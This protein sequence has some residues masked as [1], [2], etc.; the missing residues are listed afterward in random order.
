MTDPSQT[1]LKQTVVRYKDGQRSH[2]QDAVLIEEPLEIRLDCNPIAITMRTPGHDTA[3]ALGFLLSE[4][5]IDGLNDVARVVETSED[6]STLINVFPTDARLSEIASRAIRRGTI[7]S[8]SCGVCGRQQ[9]DDLLARCPPIECELRIE[10]DRVAAAIQSLDSAQTLFTETG[11]AHCA[12]ILDEDLELLAVSEDVGRH[13]AVD[14]AVGHLLQNPSARAP[15]ILATSSRGSFD[16]VQKAI[17]ARIPVVLCVS[18]VS[19]LAIDL[20]QRAAVTLVGFARDNRFTCYT[21]E[22]RVV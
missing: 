19:S 11:G 21:H 22:R 15:A 18:A 14:K 1:N 7:I 8:S 17:V 10:A 12:V 3:L 20:A 5:L 13:N 4:G 6:G 9:I 2:A 16:I